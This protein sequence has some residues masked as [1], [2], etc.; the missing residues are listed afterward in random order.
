MSCNRDVENVKM[1][2]A[3]YDKKTKEPVSGAEL[4]IINWYYEGGDYDSYNKQESYSIVTD[5]KGRFSISFKKS[6]FLEI[7][8][9]KSNYKTYSGGKEVYKKKL[10]ENFY[11]EKER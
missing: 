4:K 5:E 3:V 6:A 7:D 10:H 11:L 9:L 1:E 2:G 8:V